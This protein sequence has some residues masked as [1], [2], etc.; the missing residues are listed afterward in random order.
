MDLVHFCCT[1][2]NNYKNVEI[3]LPKD[4]MYEEARQIYNRMH[5]LYPAMIIR[6]L[7]RSALKEVV[8]FAK[9]NNLELAIRGGGH[10]IA[11]FGSTQ[12]GILVDFSPYNEV[13]IDEKNGQACISP[14]ARLRDVDHTL[15]KRGY[16]IPTGT[17]S[18]TGIAGLTL[19]GGIGWLLGTL[20]FTCENLTGADVLLATGDIVRAEEPGHEDLLWSLRGGGGNFGIVLEFRFK[21][22]R[23]PQVY[24]GTLDIP[25]AEI[26]C[27]L[28]KLFS[29]LDNHCPSNLVVAPV[30]L[31][32]EDKGVLLSID[33]CLSDS[34]DQSEIRKFEQFLG[35]KVKHNLL[36]KDY[37][38]WQSWS[39][40]RFSQP[41]RGYWKSVCPDGM[42]R[43]VAKWLLEWVKKTPGPNC[44][45]TIEH[46]N[47]ARRINATEESALP[48]TTLRYGILFSARWS[49]S[50]DDPEYVSWVKGA[51][52][53]LLINR[54]LPSYSN[55]A[56]DENNPD[57]NM[58][59]T[60]KKKLLRTKKKYDPNNVFRRN[61]NIS[62]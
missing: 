49:S 62:K 13:V 6:T 3:I 10:H 30:L 56:L 61:H 2:S 40:D 29:Y 25:E 22:S 60:S 19:G 50:D 1:L 58:F 26:E 38:E 35:P 18:D 53:S 27:V 34:I 36:T 32:T 5:N 12:G 45:I 57:S 51:S 37:L 41:M 7:N 14:G 55:Y 31:R 20:G 23:L 21:L 43:D 42:G 54:S 47:P 28:G 24:C 9:L 46:L 59:A 8:S 15:C 4:N 17:V 33:F 52:N 39:D 16:V 11:G 44:S 48:I